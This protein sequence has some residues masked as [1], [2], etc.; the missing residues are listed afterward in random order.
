MKGFEHCSLVGWISEFSSRALQ[1]PW[2]VITLDDQMMGDFSHIF[3]RC[4]HVGFN[5]M[6]I[7]GLF[8]SRRWPVP[9]GGAIDEKRRKRINEL[10]ESA[11]RRG[12]RVLS[13]LGVY[14]WGFEE[15]IEKYPEISFHSTREHGIS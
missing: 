3:D 11:H 10:L 14:S 13:G 9:L 6:V 5:K 2:P 15:I 7:W 8:V 12:V 4:Q 1:E